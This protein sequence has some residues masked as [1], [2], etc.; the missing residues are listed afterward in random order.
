MVKIITFAWAFFA[1]ASLT[2]GNVDSVKIHVVYDALYRNSTK[3]RPCPDLQMLDIGNQTSRFYGHCEVS[4]EESREEFTSLFI[5]E[6]AGVKAS[7]LNIYAK[8][9][10]F[11]ARFLSRKSKFAIH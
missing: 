2:A 3:S 7:F 6:G 10:P 5:G 4:V 11:S 8:C 1:A 9:H